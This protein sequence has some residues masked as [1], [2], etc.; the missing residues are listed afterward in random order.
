MGRKIP[1][2]HYTY[3]PATGPDLLDLEALYIR[4]FSPPYNIL[5]PVGRLKPPQVVKV[6]VDKPA[7]IPKPKPEPKPR[8]QPKKPSQ[9][10]S[11]LRGTTAKDGVYT[12]SKQVAEYLA[13]RESGMS[14]KAI[15]NYFDVEP[16][17]VSGAIRYATCPEVREREKKKSRKAV[18]TSESA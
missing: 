1:F 18:L 5:H 13:M 7:R 15:A 17:A 9:L 4:A 12:P 11:L 16:N 14:F 6:R 8:K 2:T 3:I 10:V